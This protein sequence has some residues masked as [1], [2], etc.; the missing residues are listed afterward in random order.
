MVDQEVTAPLSLIIT[1]FAPVRNVHRTWTPQ[2]QDVPEKTVVVLIDLAGGKQRLGGSALAQI[3]GL[4]GNQARNV[5]D[6][7]ILKRFVKAVGELHGLDGLVL[8]YHDRSDGGLFTTVAEMMFA[9]RLG[10]NMSLDNVAG[11]KDAEIVAALFNE[12]LGAVIQ[13]KESDLDT[14]TK[15]FTSQGLPNEAIKVVGDV[16]TPQV[17]TIERD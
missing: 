9:G 1:A 15:I 12:E 6:A 17:L 10:V 11:E 3:F 14:V 4:V 7:E 13:I 5:E 8:A 16:V 2:L